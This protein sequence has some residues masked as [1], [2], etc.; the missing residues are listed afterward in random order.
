MAVSSYYTI[1]GFCD[2]AQGERQVLENP[3]AWI[4]NADSDPEA[5]CGKFRIGQKCY[6]CHR[7]R[8]W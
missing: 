2:K 1:I 5:L 4:S 6:R 7:E 8:F 3:I